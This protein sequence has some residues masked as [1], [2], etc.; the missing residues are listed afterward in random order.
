M[1][2]DQ[3]LNLVKAGA[4]VI[5]IASYEWQRVQG[6]CRGISDELQSED[7]ENTR[8]LLWS[9]SAGL[10]SLDKKGEGRRKGFQPR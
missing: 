7:A 8:I 4:K 3:I 9:S 10:Q 2:F 1:D 5:H 6:L